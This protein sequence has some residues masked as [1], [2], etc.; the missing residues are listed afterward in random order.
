[1]IAGSWPRTVYVM[2]TV[3]RFVP[4]VAALGC[5]LAVSACG[6][7]SQIPAATQSAFRCLPSP[8]RPHPTDVKAGGSLIVS[9]RRF[10]C[11]ARYP[12]GHRYML[13]L[14][15]VGRAA[16]VRLGA[17]PVNRNGAF[18][19]MV[20]IPRTASPG[21]S[22][23]IVKGSSFD[24]CT[25]PAGGSCASYAASIRV[26]PPALGARNAGALTRIRDGCPRRQPLRSSAGAPDALAPGAPVS[27]MFCVYFHGHIFAKAGY[28][29]GPLDNALNRS[30][31]KL[32]SRT[33]CAGTATGPSVVVLR[34]R[35]RTRHVVLDVGGCEVT[36][37]TGVPRQLS[38]RAEGSLLR[39]YTNA[40]ERRR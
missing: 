15:Q 5:V 38:G 29:G 3:N 26:L 33:F 39:A 8:L 4:L 30:L 14:G 21:D 18:R 35:S 12:S 17:F 10:A 7:D 28:K 9:S 25:H 27:T 22:Y 20:H 36:M 24:W 6:A 34:Y 1:M 16:P 13:T 11:S 31:A 40:V 2:T 19:A 32:P 23:V 37:S